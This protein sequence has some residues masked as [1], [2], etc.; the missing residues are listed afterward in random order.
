MSQRRAANIRERRRMH[1]L[2]EGFDRLRTKVSDCEKSK[3]VSFEPKM[4]P[5]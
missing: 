5:T 3:L 2:N 4:R 1:N